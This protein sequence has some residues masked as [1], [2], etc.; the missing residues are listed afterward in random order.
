MIVYAGIVDSTAFVRTKRPLFGMRGP[1]QAGNL[2][3]TLSISGLMCVL[4]IAVVVSGTPRL[5]M[6]NWHT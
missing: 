4:G 5:V 6:G 1:C 2:A 3:A